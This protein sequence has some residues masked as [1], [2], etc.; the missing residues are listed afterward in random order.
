MSR[1]LRRIVI[2]VGLLLALAI[3]TALCTVLISP[4]DRAI[5]VA[6]LVIASLEAIWQGVQLSKKPILDLQFVRDDI[7]DNHTDYRV[8]LTNKGESASQVH[9]RMQLPKKLFHQWQNDFHSRK[10]HV[11]D[12][13]QPNWECWSVRLDNKSDGVAVVFNGPPGFFIEKSTEVAIVRSSSGRGQQA[14]FSFGYTIESPGM[15]PK[16]GKV[17]V[18][19]AS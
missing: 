9:L 2:V 19:N 5:A 8:V 6:A 1:T 18:G 12:R 15:S 7:T 3:V 11:L 10:S 13:L 17:L 14:H 16:S 4:I